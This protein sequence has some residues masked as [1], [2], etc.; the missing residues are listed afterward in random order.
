MRLGES[1]VPVGLSYRRKTGWWVGGGGTRSCCAREAF[2]QVRGRLWS[3]AVTQAE[4][5]AV[6]D[7]TEWEPRLEH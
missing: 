2:H 3:G 1:A 7:G 6:R 4:G 5:A